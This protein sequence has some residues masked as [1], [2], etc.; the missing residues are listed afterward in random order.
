MGSVALLLLVA[1]GNLANLLLGRA[2]ER[3]REF[4]VQRAMGAPRWRIVRR[5]MVEAVL[6]AVVGG[7]LGVM[8]AYALGTGLE[9]I[10]TLFLP[11]AVGGVVDGW[12]LFFTA[13]V[14]LLTGVL[15]GLGPALHASRVDTAGP[16]L[17]GSR[18]GTRGVRGQRIQRGL[19]I[20]EIAVTVVLLVGAGLLLRSFERLGRVDLGLAMDVVTIELHGSA[21]WELEPEAAG[22]LW[23][24]VLDAVRGVPGVM[25][26]GAIDYV[27][28][29]GSFSCD[30]VSRADRPPP[31]PGEGEC[32]ETR[33]TQPG[34]LEA[35]G[36]PLLRGRSIGR[37]DERDSPPVVVVDESMAEAY[38]PGEDAIGKRLRVHTRIH[39]VVGIVA[40]LRHFG[41]AGVTR[42]TVYIPT[43]QEGWSGSTRGLTL[44][45]RGPGDPGNLVPSIRQAVEEV[46]PVIAVG[47]IRSLKDLFGRQLA[48][49]RFRTFLLGAFGLA[50]V[51]LAVLGIGGVMAHAVASRVREM[52]VRMAVGAQPGEVRGLIV[53]EGLL[54]TS[55]G[56]LVGL[57]PA[58]LLGG[59]ADALLF[60]VS[61]RDPL[62]FAS[63][64]LLVATVGGAASYL[65]ARRASRVDPAAA[66]S[67]D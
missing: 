46:N 30:G 47:R 48:G 60:E 38:W 1:C 4:A 50:A 3:W 55:A 32:A 59:A 34:A 33:S 28:M 27:P 20:G 11:R 64:T 26:A 56:L 66:L 61:A 52:G 15:F 40:D 6:L 25:A 8:V 49:P 17:V 10:G 9:R 31:P 42:P 13:G 22:T 63:V 54:L 23:S 45:V 67:L 18:G 57:I 24:E 62:V 65:P 51:V 12:V 19:V 43:P 35:L 44:V 29:S 2:L 16:G 53:R 39:E 58:L 7:A 21:W 36:V 41:P 5:G 14:T 37:G